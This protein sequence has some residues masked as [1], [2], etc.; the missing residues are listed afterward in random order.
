MTTAIWAIP[1]DGHARLIEEDAAEMLAV[2]EH[3]GLVGQIG[4]AGI[5]QIDARQTVLR[6]DLLRPQ[7]LLHRH[8]IVGAALDGRVVGD[9]HRLPAMDEADSGD[10][11]GPVHVALVHAESRERADFEKGRAGIDQPGDALAGQELAAPDVA[12]ARFRRAALGRRAAARVEFV[13]SAR[14]PAAF[15]S[16]SSVDAPNPLF[17]LVISPAFPGSSSSTSAETRKCSRRHRQHDVHIERTTRCQ[18][19]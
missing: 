16:S 14:Q 3:L 7:V 13:D 18:F 17:N 9:D 19:G 5:D 2:R 4:A 1:A 6:R 12:L 15:A 10:E 8:R 11:P